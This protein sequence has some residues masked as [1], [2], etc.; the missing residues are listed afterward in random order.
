MAGL[1]GYDVPLAANHSTFNFSDTPF[2]GRQAATNAACPN[3]YT[4]GPVPTTAVPSSRGFRHAPALNIPTLHGDTSLARIPEAP[5]AYG[6]S[7]VGYESM[8][9]LER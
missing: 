3:G 7:S 1:H 4:A 2:D 8:G 9:A 5:S 6:S